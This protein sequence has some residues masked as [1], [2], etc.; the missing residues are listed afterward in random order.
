MD[1][2]E[3]QDGIDRSTRLAKSSRVAVL[4]RNARVMMA[5]AFPNQAAECCSR[6]S[7]Y[8]RGR[9][10]EIYLTLLLPTTIQEIV[11]V[12]AIENTPSFA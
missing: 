10:V 6:R 9:L 7:G 12:D 2:L 11:R 3:R 1:D 4:K 5:V 8:L